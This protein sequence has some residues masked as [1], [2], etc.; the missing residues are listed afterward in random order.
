MSGATTQYGWNALTHLGHRTYI[1]EAVDL[2]AVVNFANSDA[3]TVISNP[4]AGALQLN[5]R[6]I[7]APHLKQAHALLAR[8]G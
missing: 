1:Q 2:A 6:M 8:V 5:G 4:D 3:I 7:D